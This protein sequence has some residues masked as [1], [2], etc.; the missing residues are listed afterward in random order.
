MRHGGGFGQVLDHD[1]AA[2]QVI[3][4]VL[5]ARVCPDQVG[6][7]LG[8]TGKAAGEAGALHGIQRQK[9]SAACAL[10]LQKADGGAGTALVL[11]DDVLQRKAERCLNGGLVALFDG[12]DARHGADDAPQTTARSGLLAVT[13]CW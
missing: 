4:D 6:G 11:D 10:V 1:D 5:V 2:E 9:R 8:G 13:F 3:D 7:D 12:D